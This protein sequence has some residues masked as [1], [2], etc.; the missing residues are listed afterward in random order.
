MGDTLQIDSV[1]SPWQTTQIDPFRTPALDYIVFSFSM[2][3]TLQI[4][5]VNS[6]WDYS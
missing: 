5:S 4:D 6:P 3:D 1:K 2:G